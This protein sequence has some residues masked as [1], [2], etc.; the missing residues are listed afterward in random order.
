MEKMGEDV[1][2]DNTLSNN[3][4]GQ[5]WEDHF[6]NLFTKIEGG[7][8]TTMNKINT[9]I[10]QALNE[11]F[12]M[13]EMTAV[14]KELK[15]KKAV[16]PDSIANEFL[17]LAPNDILKLILDFLNLNLKNGITCSKWCIDLISVIHKD[18]PKDDPNNYRG[19]CIMNT[20]LK[21]LCSI[22]NNRLTLY[23]SKNQLINSEQI[24]F[25]KNSRTAD[26]ILTLKTIVNITIT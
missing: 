22:L 24:G 13:E 5:K 19:I 1:S 2:T 9:P 10:N 23:C 17:K 8:D 15:N 25:Q 18:G 26:H 12:K 3:L 7:I 14:I 4:D 21:V 11:E 16:G 6:K 20:L